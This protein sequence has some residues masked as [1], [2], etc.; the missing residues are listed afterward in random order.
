MRP[1]N[2]R[3]I[4]LLRGR[5]TVTNALTVKD[6]PRKR[7]F[8][9]HAVV[10]RY[11]HSFTAPAQSSH[12]SFRN[13]K[14]CIA[15]LSRERSRVPTCMQGIVLT[16]TF[17]SKQRINPCTLLLQ[18]GSWSQNYQLPYY[19][20]KSTSRVMWCEGSQCTYK[21]SHRAGQLQISFSFNLDIMPI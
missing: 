8:Q 15:S 16:G 11:H 18:P 1:T 5:A 6:Q 12:L 21:C 3:P 4:L 14:L 9:E 19:A 20:A 7:R 2:C 17:I 10:F 13:L